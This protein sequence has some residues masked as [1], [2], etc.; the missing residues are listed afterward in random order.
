MPPPPGALPE[1]SIQTSAVTS[2]GGV[3]ATFAVP[4]LITIPSDGAD[5]GV[6]I[7]TLE[8]DAKMS[9]VSIPK[10]DT[11][12]YLSVSSIQACP[13]TFEKTN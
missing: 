3:S 11:K 8:L 7:A 12:T 1:M 4:G 2:K 6:T 5:H 13:Q 10:K 9:W